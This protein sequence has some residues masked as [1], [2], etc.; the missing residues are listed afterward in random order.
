MRPRYATVVLIAVLAGGCAG[1]AA[2]PALPPADSTTQP[3]ATTLTIENILQ[4]PL[5]GGRDTPG[6]LMH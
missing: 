2:R 4:W 6:L 5:E 3:Q 1:T